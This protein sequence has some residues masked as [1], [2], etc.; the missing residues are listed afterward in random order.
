MVKTSFDVNNQEPNPWTTSIRVTFQTCGEMRTGTWKCRQGW[1]IVVWG[2][3]QF[4][5]WGPESLAQPLYH[6]LDTRDVVV[7]GANEWKQAFCG[8]LSQHSHTWEETECIYDN[9]SFITNHC[10]I[11]WQP[12]TNLWKHW[13]CIWSA[14]LHLPIFCIDHLNSH[15]AGSNLSASLFPPHNLAGGQHPETLHLPSSLQFWVFSLVCLPGQ[16]QWFSFSCHASCSVFL[17]FCRRGTKECLLSGSE[18]KLVLSSLLSNGLLQ[19]FSIC[20]CSCW[21]ENNQN[22]CDIWA[23]LQLL[24]SS[25]PTEKI[26]H[27]QGWDPDVVLTYCRAATSTFSTLTT[28]L[29]VWP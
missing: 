27:I 20:E 15:P 29:R 16:K 6:A 24:S 25:R 2:L 9:H 4:A 1:E 22:D 23:V 14:D 13:Q 19:F 17:D 26:V 7:G 8:V 10:V 5:E 11:K 12:N 3:I 21:I 18:S 28:A